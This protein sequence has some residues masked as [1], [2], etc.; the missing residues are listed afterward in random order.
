MKKI[1]IFH[2]NYHFYGRKN[3]S[4]LHGC[5]FVMSKSETQTSLCSYRKVP[6]SDARKLCC[7]LPK[8]QT[9]RPNLRVFHQEDANGIATSEDP[10]Q[11]V[12][13]L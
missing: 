11:T 12:P 13:L 4:L 1:T 9:K 6:I 3:C 10:D 5:V 8:I 2:P 7:N